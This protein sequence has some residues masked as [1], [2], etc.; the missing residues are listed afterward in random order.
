NDDEKKEKNDDD[1]PPQPPPQPRPAAPTASCRDRLRRW[2]QA[3]TARFIHSR[4]AARQTSQ[5]GRRSLFIAGQY[6]PVLEG[7]DKRRVILHWAHT[8]GSDRA[9]VFARTA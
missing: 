7:G 9:E 3:K 1:T 6:R 2:A 5:R 8:F 4:R